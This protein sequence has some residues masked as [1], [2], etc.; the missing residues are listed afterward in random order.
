MVYTQLQPQ[1]TNEF[2]KIK[3]E[4]ERNKKSQSA[5][6][7]NFTCNDLFSRIYFVLGRTTESK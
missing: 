2:N 7:W 3:I 1:S 5:S 6:T 4:N